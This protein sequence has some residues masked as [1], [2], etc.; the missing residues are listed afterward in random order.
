MRYIL[1]TCGLST[2]TNYEPIK[3]LKI[4]T[5]ANKQK[6]EIER[7][8]L[9]EFEKYYI[10][11]ERKF[12]KY[13]L[14]EV[15]K[16]SAELNV[17]FTF[18]KNNIDKNDYHQLL[19]TDTYFGKKSAHLI[20]AYL[21]HHGMKVEL[22]SLVDL[23]TSKEEEFH[24]ALAELVKELSPKLL[25]YKEAGYEIVF[26]LTG[27]F[28]SINS[29]LQTVASLYAHKS[30]YMFEN[31]QEIL[32]I[33]QLPIK[34]DEEIVLKNIDI[35]RKLAL[36]I[37][38]DGKAVERVPKSLVLKIGEDYTLSAWGEVIWQ[39]EK[40]KIYSQK[41]LGSP[42]MLVKISKEFEKVANAL[43]PNRLY[44]INEKIDQLIKFKKFGENPASLSF[45]ELKGKP[46]HKST[47]EFYINSDE[48]K[49]GYCHIEKNKIVLDEYGEHL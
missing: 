8:F 48:A 49:R 43:Q 14:D 35:F 32:T 33:P 41:F 17:L 20:E 46:K 42:F 11:L 34:I 47:H 16:A 40:R 29:F 37:K 27:G 3:K 23:Q 7:E 12:L 15:K 5:Y 39:Q 9:E 19:H 44:E 28:K 38:T 21:K 1:T 30:I 24:V 22:F 6:N 26:N 18:Y 31:G 4:Y 13:S 10:E 25:D 36:N 2:F 45:K